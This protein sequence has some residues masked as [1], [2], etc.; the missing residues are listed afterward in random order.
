MENRKVL[1]V[2]KKILPY[3]IMFFIS[4][5]S[6]KLIFYKGF[7]SGDDVRFHFANIND[8]YL[9][10]K[11]GKSLF[12]SNTLIGGL[13]YGKG[14]FYS[15]LSH[16]TVAF[17]CL[18]FDKFGMT[19][20]TSFKLVILLS[21]YISG[22]FMY[23]FSNRISKNKM[24]ISLLVGCLFI[25][26]PYRLFNYFC[27]SAFAEAYAMLWLPLFFLGLY[28]YVYDKTSPRA[29]VE[30]AIGG[31]CIYLSHNITGLFAY[32]YGIIFLLFYIKQ[33]I[34]RFKTDK[35]YLIST[36]VTIV[37]MLLILCIILIPSLTMLKNGYYNVSFDDRMWT[38]AGH[39]ATDCERTL[40]YTGFLNLS[41]L[42]GN[43][44][45]TNRL[46]L[47][48]VYFGLITFLY[49]VI[50]KVLSNIKA[51]KYF[52]IL[53]STAI[54]L[55]IGL[56]VGKFYT[57]K[58]FMLA[59]AS[60]AILFVSTSYIVQFIDY[61][62]DKD[63]LLKKDKRLTYSILLLIIINILLVSVGAIW[64]CIPH[65]YT[66]I[67]FPWRLN[68]FIYLFINILVI[69]ILTTYGTKLLKTSCVMIGIIPFL[70]Q[71]CVE[72]RI[73]YENVSSENNYPYD[74]AD[75]SWRMHIDDQYSYYPGSIGAN[76]EYLPYIYYYY[77][78]KGYK[79][80]Y[81]NSLYKNV[82]VLV[83]HVVFGNFDLCPKVIYGNA[84]ISNYHRIGTTSKLE[85]D[86]NV[87]ATSRIKLPVFYN[88]DLKIYVLNK[89]TN[90]NNLVEAILNNYHS[91][92]DFMI[93]K[94]NYKV[95]VS[96]PGTSGLTP[97]ILEG[98]GVVSN[99]CQDTPKFSFK[100]SLDKE[101][102]IQV[103]LIYYKGYEIKLTDEFGNVTYQKLEEPQDVDF[104]VAFKA[105]KGNYDVEIKYVGTSL[106]KLSNTLLGFGFVGLYCVV[107][108]NYFT[109]DRKKYIL[110]SL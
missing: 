48:F 66:T 56:L 16:F 88:T 17:V 92:A 87:E 96:Y 24:W 72:K 44:L 11:E 1:H 99:S 85:F 70:S 68:G 81:D 107:L 27:R 64:Y 3:F 89:D 31:V 39:V 37:S 8:L 4:L 109:E 13:G 2:F 97:Q 91:F 106:M 67:Q 78:E 6:C 38:N 98:S 103:P 77:E 75:S 45:T 80:K 69:I 58:E 32:T 25:L 102:L 28:D 14:L 104:L 22:I 76:N 30:I 100:L 86:L 50:E 51:L 74:T 71:A 20:M 49:I 47:Y 94:G 63:D 5:I 59:I 35:N 95:S 33:I 82:R 41:W 83:D 26:G 53:I 42:Q 9:S 34:V 57:G 29:F 61:N 12:I 60:V 55:L 21:V 73:A 65:I 15:P 90:E 52:H 105:P 18:I 54:Y 23:K 46:F 93:D 43:G 40:A 19:L 62:L 101:S 110:K 108:F 36:I 7:A 84:K 10:L 79:A